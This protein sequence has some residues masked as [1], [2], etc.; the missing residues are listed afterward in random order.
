M[1]S[2]ALVG[3]M[4][5]KAE[6]LKESMLVHLVARHHRNLCPG[7]QAHR[8]AYLLSAYLAHP[9]VTYLHPRWA[10]M[11]PTRV[12]T[13]LVRSTAAAATQ[14]QCRPGSRNCNRRGWGAA[15]VGEGTAPT[16][17]PAPPTAAGATP[18]ACARATIRPSGAAGRWPANTGAACRCPRLHVSVL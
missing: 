13:Q 9:T 8:N 1:A 16:G 5:P 10:I 17:A 14:V 6:A 12:V 3:L 15:R 4:G 18:R 11:A 7:K 2:A